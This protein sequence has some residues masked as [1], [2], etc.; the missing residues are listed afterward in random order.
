MIFYSQD[1]EVLTEFVKYNP[2]TCFIMT[3][4]G[5]PLPDKANKIRYRLSSILKKQKIKIIDANSQTT[6]R[7][8]L[9]KIWK[10]IH[11]VP[12][13]IAIIT[14]DMK[15][16]TISNIFYELGILNAL[17]KDTIV[18]KTSS[19]K[20]PSDFVRTEYINFDSEFT[21]KVENF[22]YQMFELAEHYDTMAE[23]L[24]ANPN[25]S[26][27]YWRRSFLI[28]GDN[29]YIDK[30]EIIFKENEFDHQSKLFVKSFLRNRR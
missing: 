26:I 20:I 17:G 10:I 8:F 14:E 28:T 3:Q 11:S 13:G 24:E 18:I 15:Q 12:F 29:K 4:L 22:I 19:F 30:A 6:G 25:L 2:R 7:D 27:D 9:N 1:R 16:S 21:N 23:S 5:K